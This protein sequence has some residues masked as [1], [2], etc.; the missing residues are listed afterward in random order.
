MGKGGQKLVL[1]L[2]L[3]P[4]LAD[5][6][7]PLLLDQFASRDVCNGTVKAVEPAPLSLAVVV[8]PAFAEDPVD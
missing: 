3:V 4:E 7:L 8:Y 1:P 2:V 5:E 6:P